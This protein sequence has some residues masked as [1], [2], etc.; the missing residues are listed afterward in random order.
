[1]A[2][3]DRGVQREPVEAVALP[4]EAVV[5]ALAVLHVADEGAGEVLQVPADLLLGLFL[6]GHVDD[7]PAAMPFVS[8]VKIPAPHHLPDRHLKCAAAPIEPAVADRLHIA[9]LP[10]FGDGIGGGGGRKK[11]QHD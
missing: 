8:H 5:L 6:L 4:E 1:M 9:R 10:S 11:K 2:G 7:R 3:Q